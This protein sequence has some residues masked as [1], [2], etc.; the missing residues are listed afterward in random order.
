MLLVAVGAG[1]GRMQS[2]ARTKGH[3]DVLSAVIHFT[4]D[5]LA[6]PAGRMFVQLGEFSSGLLNARSL[7]VQNA[8]LKAQLIGHQAYAEQIQLLSEEIEGYRKILALPPTTRKVVN[9]DVIGF[10]KADGTLIL[11]GGSERGI[12]PDLPVVNGEG[13]VGIVQTVTHGE[14]HVATLS[15]FGVEIFGIDGSRNPPEEGLINGS[16]EQYL[17]MKMLN[18]KDPV[19]SGDIILTSLKSKNIPGGK[20]VGRVI[21]VEDDPYYGTKVLKIDPVALGTI[22]EVQVLE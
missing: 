2:A 6:I 17:T 19:A 9:L 7:S 12:R 16:G 1:L 13:L 18:P 20:V 22:R 5:P 14:C 8:A 21:S 10:S 4:V 11:D 15:S 3:L